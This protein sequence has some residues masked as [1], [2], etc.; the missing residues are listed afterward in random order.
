MNIRPSMTPA[1]ETVKMERLR[2][3]QEFERRKLQTLTVAGQSVIS[4][5]WR[6]YRVLVRGRTHIARPNTETRPKPGSFPGA[7]IASA[8]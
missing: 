1:I 5:R 8:P 2:A 4:R 6:G 3:Q 7:A